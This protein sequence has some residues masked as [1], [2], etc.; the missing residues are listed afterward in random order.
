[1]FLLIFFVK[2]TNIELFQEYSGQDDQ[3]LYLDEREAEL[4]RKEEEKRQAQLSVPG[5]INPHDLPEV[6]EDDNQIPTPLPEFA[7]SSLFV[8]AAPS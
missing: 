4:R 6:M 1:M 2:I 7:C 8:I 5:I 3:D